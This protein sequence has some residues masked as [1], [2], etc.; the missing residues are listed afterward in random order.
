M[1][2]KCKFLSCR[3]CNRIFWLSGDV[4]EVVDIRS[5]TTKLRDIGVTHTISNSST[6]CSKKRCILCPFIIST[7]FR[8]Q[9]QVWGIIS[10]E[11][12]SLHRRWNDGFI[13][14]DF[15]ISDSVQFR[16]LNFPPWPQISE[17]VR[18]QTL[19]GDPEHGAQ[20][21]L[22]C[23]SSKLPMGVQLLLKD[24]QVPRVKPSLIWQFYALYY[25]LL[26]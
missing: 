19:R 4:I 17:K 11:N 6:I 2:N 21:H 16:S 14:D 23:R 26:C 5:Y 3:C 15:V 24:R 8:H 22:L 20:V 1:K 13:L 9:W 10:K 25:A 12:I 18:W 7:T